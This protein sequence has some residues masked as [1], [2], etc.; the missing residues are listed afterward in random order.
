MTIKLSIYDNQE[1][2]IS[3]SKDESTKSFSMSLKHEMGYSFSYS[4][5]GIDAN[6]MKEI[7]NAMK[8]IKPI[9]KKYQ[10]A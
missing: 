9:F 5:N 7:E 6:D 3:A 4:G 1:V 8:V 10:R 2:D